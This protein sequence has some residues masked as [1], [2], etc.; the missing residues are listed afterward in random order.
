MNIKCVGWWGVLWSYVT[1]GRARKCWGVARILTSV[2]GNQVMF[3][4]RL[5]SS[6]GGRHVSSGE[7]GS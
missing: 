4:Q 1:E 2:A 5:E 3:Q 6:E 7:Q